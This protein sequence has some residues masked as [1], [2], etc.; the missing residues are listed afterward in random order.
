MTKRTLFAKIGS[1]RHMNYVK[2]RLRDLLEDLDAKV[3]VIGVVADRWPQIDLSGDDEGIA[4]NYIAQEIGFCPDKIQAVERYATLKGYVTDIIDGSAALEVDVGVFEP[5]IVMVSVP[6]T[7]LQ[8]SLADGRII[9]LKRIAEFYGLCKDLPT[10][11]KIIQI[12]RKRNHIEAELATNQFLKYKLWIESLMDRLIVIGATSDE[13]QKILD[14]TGLK[15]DVINVEPLGAFEHALT[16]KL[17]TDA[18]G[19]VTIVGKRLKNARFRVFSSRKL[20]KA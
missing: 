2:N 4:T 11:V 1:P 19:L 16:C 10:Q 18:V 13:V 8:A 14:Y 3:E 12:D 6:L 7:H 5:S 9:E 17:G 20:W 15:R